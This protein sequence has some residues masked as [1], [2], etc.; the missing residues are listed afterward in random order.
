MTKRASEYHSALQSEPPT[1]DKREKTIN[2]VLKVIP[3]ILTMEQNMKLAAL[4][5]QDELKTALKQAKTGKSPGIDGLPY[6]FYKHMATIPRD[7][8]KGDPDLLEILTSVV[9]DIEINGIDSPDF[10][11]GAMFLLFKK[12]DPTK[13]ENY[14]PI[15]LLNTDYKLYTKTIANKL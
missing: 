4:T 11:K 6:E 7:K 1:S 5:T 14:R 15:T 12:N 2:E 3:N 10:A 8:E 9:N 13:I